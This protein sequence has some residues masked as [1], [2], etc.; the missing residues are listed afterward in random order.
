VSQFSSPTG[1]RLPSIYPDCSQSGNV[2]SFI[3]YENTDLKHEKSR[4]TLFLSRLSSPTRSRCPPI[5]L[6]VHN[7][8]MSHILSP[9]RPTKQ[10][11]S[12]FFINKTPIVWSKIVVAYDLCVRFWSKIVLA[13]DFA[14]DF[15][16]EFGAKSYSR[17]I[18][19]TILEQNRTRRDVLLGR[20]L[21]S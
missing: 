11:K 10:T 20:A 9:M 2:T 21:V 4:F 16:Y 14:Y 5:V 8:K 1:G 15:A 3:T 13:Y 6:V 17:T 12:S 18:L 7:P 19:R